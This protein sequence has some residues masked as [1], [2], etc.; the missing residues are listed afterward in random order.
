MIGS[1][2]NKTVLDKIKTIKF[3]FRN[4]GKYSAIGELVSKIISTDNW[5]ISYR[6]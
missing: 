2:Q 6:M 5:I 3:H 1:K 4:L